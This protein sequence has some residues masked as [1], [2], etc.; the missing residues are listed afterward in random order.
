MDRWTDR[1]TKALYGNIKTLLRNLQMKSGKAELS[2]VR[3]IK[4]N[5]S[6]YCCISEWDG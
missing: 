2:L 6:F 4:C 1:Q 5:K 3:D